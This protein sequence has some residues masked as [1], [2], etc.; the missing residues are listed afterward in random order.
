MSW[1]RRESQR[2]SQVSRPTP[3]RCC[4]L[5]ERGLSWPQRSTSLSPPSW[6]ALLSSARIPTMKPRLPPPPSPNKKNPFSLAFR[7]VCKGSPPWLLAVVIFSC[8]LH[9]CK[10]QG[11]PILIPRCVFSQLS[12]AQLQQSLKM[13]GWG[14]VN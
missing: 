13:D 6:R 4:W 5:T 12:V 8:L 10:E 3:R 9:G 14:L 7:S 1:A 2:P 11:R